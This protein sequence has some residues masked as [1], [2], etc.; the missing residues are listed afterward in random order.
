MSILTNF[1]TGDMKICHYPE[2][3]DDAELVLLSIQKECRT[4]HSQ[5]ISLLRRF[6]PKT[7]HT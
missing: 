4:F 2:I 3:N 6:T 1:E 7:V 5:D